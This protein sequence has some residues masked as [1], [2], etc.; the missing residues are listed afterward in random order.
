[1]PREKMFSV[2]E[3]SS[4]FAVRH[5]QIGGPNE[6]PMS[7]GVDCLFDDNGEPLSPGTDGFIQAWED[8]LNSDEQETLAAYF[9]ELVRD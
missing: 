8:A 5:N 3:Y 2:I 1:M 6:V 7:D 9:P 4:H